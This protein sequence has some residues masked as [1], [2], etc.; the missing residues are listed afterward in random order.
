MEGA[1]AE[2][3]APEQTFFETFISL[4]EDLYFEIS[5][6]PINIALLIAILVLVYK[7]FKGRSDDDDNGPKPDPPL[8]KMKKQDMTLEELRKYDGIQGDGRVLCAINGR[9]FD[10]TKGKRFYGPGGP[11]SSFAGH[12][13]SRALAMFQTDLVKEEYDDLSDL[14]NSQMESIRE[15]D[16]QLAEKYDIVGR[17]LKP[18]EEPSNYSDDEDGKDEKSKDD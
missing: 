7:I 12:D 4:V 2:T 8:P 6:S 13:A 10:V 9:V 1:Q 3:E 16:A 11:Y 15:W 18:G 14:D 17:L 5:S